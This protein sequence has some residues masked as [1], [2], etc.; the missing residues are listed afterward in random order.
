MPKALW[1]IINYNYHNHHNIDVPIRRTKIFYAEELSP[2]SIKLVNNSKNSSA[3]SSSLPNNSAS[4]N[5][6]SQYHQNNQ[7]S[8]NNQNNKAS[9]PWEQLPI[10]IL[11]FIFSIASFKKPRDSK[12]SSLLK[13]IET[14]LKLSKLLIGTSRY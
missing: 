9:S 8:K 11:V 5:H 6:A 14:L 3:H 1:K 7:I 10:E 12:I 4:A 2:P 13:S